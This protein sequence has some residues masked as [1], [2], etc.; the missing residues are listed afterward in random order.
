M[1]P[2]LYVGQFYSV[3]WLSLKHIWQPRELSP[4]ERIQHD[5]MVRAFRLEQERA[6]AWEWLRDQKRRN[7]F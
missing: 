6:E 2:T 5:R 1:I 4:V 3:P 7:P